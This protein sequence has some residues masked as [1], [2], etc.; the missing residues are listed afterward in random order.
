MSDAGRKMTT[1]LG[2]NC[3]LMQCQM[4]SSLIKESFAKSFMSDWHLASRGSSL[5][6]KESFAKS[7]MSDWHLASRGSSLFSK[8]VFSVFNKGSAF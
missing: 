6:I 5:L 2:S 8:K 7:F 4:M 1:C 3:H